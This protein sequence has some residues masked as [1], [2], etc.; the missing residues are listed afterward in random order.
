MTR[1]ETYLKTWHIMPAELGRRAGVSRAGLYKVR[2]GNI[3]PT[4]RVMVALTD[5]VSAMRGK[6]VY[7]VELFELAPADESIFCAIVGKPAE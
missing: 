7:V 2:M 4:R 6:P 1:L 3:D 5:A